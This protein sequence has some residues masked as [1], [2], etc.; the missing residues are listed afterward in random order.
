MFKEDVREDLHGVFLD[1]GEFAD[2]VD[3]EG[4]RIAAVLDEP[5]QGEAR[6]DAGLATDTYRL[7]A[8]DRDLPARRNPGA[9]LTV[10]KKVF[11]IIRWRTDMGMAEVDIVRA[12]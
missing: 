12:Q 4:R 7:Y 6:F 2:E 11:R 1:L 9:T 5:V 3:V 10:N 8:H